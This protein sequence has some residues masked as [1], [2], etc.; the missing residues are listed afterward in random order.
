[1][2][3]TTKERLFFVGVFT[4]VVLGLAGLGYLSYISDIPVKA[5]GKVIGTYVE[6]TGFGAR[7]ECVLEIN[8]ERT[9]TASGCTNLV[10]DVVK[11]NKYKYYASILRDK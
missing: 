9:H 2:N 3:E 7:T 1:M 4:L 5:E 10:G 11:V 6:S 8:G